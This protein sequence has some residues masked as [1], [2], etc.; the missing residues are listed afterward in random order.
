METLKFSKRKFDIQRLA[1]QLVAISDE[2][3]D[4]VQELNY[5]ED[6][7]MF[8]ECAIQTSIKVHILRNIAHGR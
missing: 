5:Y 3:S 1:D 4:K 7:K 8:L 6:N 2:L